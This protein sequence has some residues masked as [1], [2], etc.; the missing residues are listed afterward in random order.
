MDRMKD[1][2]NNFIEVGVPTI[3]FSQK[4]TATGL[5]NLSTVATFFSGVTATT[6]QP[7]KPVA[8]DPHSFDDH[9]TPLQDLVNALWISS[10]VFSIASAINSQ[11]AYH[12]R[13]AQYRSPRSYV[14]WWVA[15]WIT[16]TPLF[17]LVG[18]VIAF[19]AGLCLFTYSSGQSRAVSVVIT[20]FTVVTSSALLCVGL[21][22]AS[23]RWT[24]A[25]TKGK[26]WLLDILEEHTEKAGTVTGV[27][28]AKRAASMGVKRTRTMMGGIKRSM[29]DTSKRVTGVTGRMTEAMTSLVTVPRTLLGRSMS[30]LSVNNGSDH[31]DEESQDGTMRTDSPT[32]YM[33][34]T[35]NGSGSLGINGASEKRKLSGL[36][37]GVEDTIHEDKPLV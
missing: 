22:F 1:S 8:H 19:S 34:G 14:P 18:S 37:K 4:H 35:E 31:R 36:G 3:R 6:L 13:A 21:W 17:F 7:M 20:T 16:R 11:L 30:A 10:L 23:E 28:P 5:Q 32:N 15:I 26:R 29:T 2:L 27:I 33:F 24:Y 12:W 9:G 25:K